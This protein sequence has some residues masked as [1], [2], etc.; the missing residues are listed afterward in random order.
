MAAADG[1]QMTVHHS[2]FTLSTCPIDEPYEPCRQYHAPDSPIYLLCHDT[3]PEF[4]VNS[5]H[6]LPY[7]CVTLLPQPQPHRVRFSWVWRWFL[8]M[9]TDCTLS[10][11]MSWAILL[12]CRCR[13]YRIFVW[14]LLSRSHI[15]GASKTISVTSSSLFEPSH[16]GSDD[17]LD[18][19]VNVVERKNSLS[20][21]HNFSMAG[22]MT[23]T[24]PRIVTFFVDES[25][26]I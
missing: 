15:P 18:D 1:T 22:P 13:N 6:S 2:R 14:P 12:Y 16:A 10:C 11:S 19:V 26:F 3:P 20:I 24:S 17:W 25:I 23:K 21:T 5:Q 9:D 7:M 8:S 4:R